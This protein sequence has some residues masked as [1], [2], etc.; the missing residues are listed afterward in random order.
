MKIHIVPQKIFVEPLDAVRPK[1]DACF[2]PFCNS[3]S[4]VLIPIF[5]EFPPLGQC[6]LELEIF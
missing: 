2:F 3:L 4:F 5:K 1:E 6:Y